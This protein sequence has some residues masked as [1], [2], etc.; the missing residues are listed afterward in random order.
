METQLN[1]G[2]VAKKKVKNSFDKFKNKL[3]GEI[4]RENI[5]ISL[6]KRK[7]LKR[8]ISQII[9][10][11]YDLMIQEWEFSVMEDSI[12]SSEFERQNI[13]IF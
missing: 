8:K 7:E 3:R 6:A 13:L 11:R 2:F 9:D 5:V 4:I 12:A 1:L 10:A